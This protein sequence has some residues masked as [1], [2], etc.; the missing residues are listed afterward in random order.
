MT[1]NTAKFVAFMSATVI[2]DGD[3]NLSISDI[4]WHYKQA[5][6]VHVDAAAAVWVLWSHPAA[7]TARPDSI[8]M[9]A[10][11]YAIVLGMP[12]HFSEERWEDRANDPAWL[13]WVPRGA[14]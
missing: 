2:D 12:V 10:I 7:D 3:M 4:A 5:W 11:G 14:A 13:T 1:D 8:V 9:L 6:S